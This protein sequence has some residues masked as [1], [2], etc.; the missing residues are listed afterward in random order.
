HAR[1]ARAAREAREALGEERIR[2]VEAEWPRLREEVRAEIEED[3]D[4]SGPRG[5]ALA[6]RRR[7]LIEE[8]PGG[9]PGIAASLNRMYEQ[10]DTIHG[11]DVAPMRAM[12]EYIGRALAAAREGE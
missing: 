1:A 6:Q 12:G 3:T 8:F 11:M 5:Q 4:P 10:E 9:D 7:G 2:E